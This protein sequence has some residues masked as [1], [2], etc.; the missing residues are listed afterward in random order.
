MTT[1]TMTDRELDAYLAENLFRWTLMVSDRGFG[2]RVANATGGL[3]GLPTYPVPSYSSAGDGLL[4]VLEAMRERGWNGYTHVVP[5]DSLYHAAFQHES[6]KSIVLD[7][8]DCDSLP[9][10]VAEAAY[11]ALNA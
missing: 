3:A 7:W 1:T 2:S 8:H 6:T 4:L 11:A 9:R 10:A 5:E